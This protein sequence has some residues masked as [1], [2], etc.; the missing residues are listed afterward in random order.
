MN[1]HRRAAFFF[2]DVVAL[3][4]SGCGSDAP[5]ITTPESDSGKIDVALTLPDG[6]ILN[7]VGYTLSGPAE[8]TRTGT[9]NVSDSTKVSLLLS[10]PAGGP[11]SITLSGTSTDGSTCAGASSTF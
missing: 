11:Y 2:A 3:S 9:I 10:L 5:D 7:S 4:L 1:D 6:S 8:L